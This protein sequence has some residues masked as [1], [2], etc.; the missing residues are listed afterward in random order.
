MTNLVSEKAISR[1]LKKKE[2]SVKWPMRIQY[3]EFLEVFGR[4]LLPK[5]IW[6][7]IGS[8]CGLAVDA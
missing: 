1:R 8:D 5:P 4:T 3:L 6:L 2:S 7:L